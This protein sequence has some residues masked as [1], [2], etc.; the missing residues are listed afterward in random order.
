M[1]TQAKEGYE[2]TLVL[3]RERHVELQKLEARHR[4]QQMPTDQY[5]SC[6]RSLLQGISELIAITAGDPGSH[7]PPLI[8]SEENLQTEKPI[9][10]P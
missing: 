7:A 10:N 4:R 8:S 1:R 6:R 5:L 9:C 3:L 2:Y